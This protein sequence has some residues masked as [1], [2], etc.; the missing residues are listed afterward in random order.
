M[1]TIS[2]I[3]S[4]VVLTHKEHISDKAIVAS[5]VAKIESSANNSSKDKYLQPDQVEIS[6]ASRNKLSD[7]EKEKPLNLSNKLKAKDEVEAETKKGDGNSDIDKKIRE[8]SMEILELTIKI[9]MLKAKEDKESVKEA[10]ALEVELAMKKGI[11]E[12][13][14]AMKLQMATDAANMT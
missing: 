2:S 5:E 7:E 8:L 11:L 9:E 3:S 6:E 4:T 14:V 12:A 10:Q 13:T 1:D